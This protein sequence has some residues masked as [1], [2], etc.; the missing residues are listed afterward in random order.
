MHVWV[1]LLQPFYRSDWLDGFQWQ[2]LSPLLYMYVATIAPTIA[3]GGL[4]Q[5]ATHDAM[6]ILEV[7][8]ACVVWACSCVFFFC[9]GSLGWWVG[10]ILGI[11][12][13]LGCF[14]LGSSSMP[15]THVLH[16]SIIAQSV[17]GMVFAV[18]GGQALS[19]L[20][21]TGPVVVRSM[22]HMHLYMRAN[23]T[24]CL[25]HVTCIHMI[26]SCFFFSHQAFITVV[27]QQSEVFEVDFLKLWA[28]VGLWA[29]VWLMLMAVCDSAA[30]VRFVTNFTEDVHNA[31]IATI[32][33]VEVGDCVAVWLGG[34]R[35]FACRA[36]LGV[37]GCSVA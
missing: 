34:A 26:R 24:P 13:T 33:I 17:V 12:L 10:V 25:S 19:I 5:D 16:G 29:M 23:A 32:F 27:F 11:W 28:W 4:L 31:L 36:M 21:P 37:G 30:L 35:I 8:V 9:S 14:C 15:S 3:F 6:G 1:V 22:S 20:R 2:V 18:I 7:Y